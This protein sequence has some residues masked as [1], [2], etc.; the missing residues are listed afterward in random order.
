MGVNNLSLY[1]LST[2]SDFQYKS[3]R[4]QKFSL[5]VVVPIVYKFSVAILVSMGNLITLP[6][7]TLLVSNHPILVLLIA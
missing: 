5:I 1:P 6:C 4:Y 2:I 3:S 7:T